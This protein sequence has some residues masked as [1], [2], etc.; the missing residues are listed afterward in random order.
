MLQSSDSAS[1]VQTQQEGERG[2]SSLGQGPRRADPAWCQ[3][4]QKLP[5]PQGGEEPGG[6]GHAAGSWPVFTPGG[7]GEGQPLGAGQS[8]N[9]GWNRSPKLCDLGQGPP[10]PGSGLFSSVCAICSL[11]RNLLF[12]LNLYLPAAT[13]PVPGACRQ[14]ADL[15]I[16]GRDFASLCLSF[17]LLSHSLLRG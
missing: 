16:S 10:A 11:S 5:R 17:P 15:L 8:A 3:G 2:R 6:T 14:T 12:N 13:L 4:F 1:C 7:W 9:P